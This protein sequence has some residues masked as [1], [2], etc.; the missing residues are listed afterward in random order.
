MSTDIDIDFSDRAQALKLF[1]H[2]TASIFNKGEFKPHNTGIYTTAI[3]V[4]VR[5]NLATID[6][7]SA[8]ARGY[9]KID[10]LNVGL[11]EGV[12]SE[13]HLIALMNQEPLWDLLEQDEFNKLLFHLNGYG[14]ILRQMKPCNIDQLAAV[15]AM[16]RPAKRY[17]IGK[18]WTTVMTEVWTK[19]ATDEGYA[20][21]RSHA[22]AYAM[23]I[24]VQM[25]LI[26]EQLSNTTV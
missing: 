8:E 23:A 1:N 21:R 15:L 11:Y 4:D 17:L 13:E 16:I 19:Q 20:F 9:I 18:D 5:T 12:Q 3:P 22:Y 24:I 25:N 7:K 26:C 6:Y 10:F 14:G 2:V